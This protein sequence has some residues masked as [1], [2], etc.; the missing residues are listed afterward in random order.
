METSLE[1]FTELVL[2]LNRS[3]Y[4]RCRLLGLFGVYRWMIEPADQA[5]RASLFG[6]INYVVT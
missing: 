2:W 6:E 4:T 5:K 3:K 1:I